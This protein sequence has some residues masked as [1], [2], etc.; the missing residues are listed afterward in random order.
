MANLASTN[1]GA[2]L[3]S[4]D[5]CSTASLATRRMESGARRAYRSVVVRLACPSTTWTSSRR[6]AL[7][8]VPMIKWLAPEV[9]A[10]NHHRPHSCSARGSGSIVG[11][12]PI[13]RRN[14][15]MSSS[16]RSNGHDRP[17]GT[18]VATW[19]RVHVGR[20]VILRRF[21]RRVP[22]LAPR[23]LHSQSIADIN[24]LSGSQLRRHNIQYRAIRRS[25]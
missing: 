11:Q 4:S 5:N 12:R 25:A 7:P 2:T 14:S 17:R 15:M 23:D 6:H 3:Q 16:T 19:L 13:N 22:C 1:P 24:A 21:H 9:M 20:R 8:H 18:L 10:P